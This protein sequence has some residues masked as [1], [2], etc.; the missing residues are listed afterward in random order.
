MRGNPQIE[1]PSVALCHITSGP[2]SLSKQMAS[3][4]KSLTEAL[5]Q[6]WWSRR[7]VCFS[8]EKNVLGVT[9]NPTQ[10]REII[11]KVGQIKECYVPTKVVAYASVMKKSTQDRTR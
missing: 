2:P 11:L 5:L 4:S 7:Y 6:S 3:Q 8:G 9:P 10:P 1:I